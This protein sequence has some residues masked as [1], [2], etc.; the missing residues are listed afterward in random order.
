MNKK[1]LSILIFGMFFLSLVSAQAEVK[2]GITPDNKFLYGIDI[3]L[4]KIR[5]AF[6][7]GDENKANYG[8]K[9]A[10]ERLAEFQRELDKEESSIEK[11]NKIEQNR[12]KI[13]QDVKEK[14]SS[15]EAKGVIQKVI[16]GTD[17][18]FGLRSKIE[19]VY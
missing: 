4:E 7:F 17:E 11:L 16:E 10:E 19:A 18:G 6:T 5:M 13:L 1:I 14:I 12:V 15:D 2:P 9:I 3:A 8:L